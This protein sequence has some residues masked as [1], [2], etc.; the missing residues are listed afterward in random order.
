MNKKDTIDKIKAIVGKL[1]PFGCMI[2]SV[3]RD[4]EEYEALCNYV[5]MSSVRKEQLKEFKDLDIGATIR[6]LKLSD[7]WFDVS[8]VKCKDGVLGMF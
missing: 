1:G 2:L 4:S 6:V 8:I 5:D 7:E 3:H